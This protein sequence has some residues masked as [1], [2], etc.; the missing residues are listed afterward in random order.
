M[1]NIMHSL[2]YFKE[3]YILNGYKIRITNLPNLNYV[4]KTLTLKEYL[5]FIFC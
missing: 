3:V 4:P 2:L 1:Y 5:K